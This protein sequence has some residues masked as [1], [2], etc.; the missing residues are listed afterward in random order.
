M[1]INIKSINQQKT[2]IKQKRQQ[3]PKIGTETKQSKTK[4]TLKQQK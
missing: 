3:K 4:Q 1:V 2:K